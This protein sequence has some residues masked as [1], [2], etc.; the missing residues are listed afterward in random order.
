MHVLVVIANP[1]PHDSVAGRPLEG[2]IAVLPLP[3]PAVSDGGLL[4][5]DPQVFVG[6]DSHA[7]VTSVE[8]V[9]L[10]VSPHVVMGH[11]QESLA[12]GS[13]VDDDDLIDA[14]ARL[15]AEMLS[16]AQ[17]FPVGT[18]LD[19]EGCVLHAYVPLRDR[20]ARRR[21]CDPADPHHRQTW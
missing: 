1:P 17:E 12:R 18:I 19:R 9:D 14:A 16:V 6:V 8:V 4:R 2:E 5:A 20:H 7:D 21:V 3:G 10:D 11:V 13:A 15:T